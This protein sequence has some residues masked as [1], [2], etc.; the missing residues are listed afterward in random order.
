[1]PQHIEYDEDRIRQFIMEKQAN[2]IELAWD[3]RDVFNTNEILV[4]PLRQLVSFAV[5][6]LDDLRKGPF[7]GHQIVTAA[8]KKEVKG[9]KNK[10]LIKYGNL[11]KLANNAP[12]LSAEECSDVIR[13]Y[14]EVVEMGGE[15]Y[16]AQ[17]KAR[18]YTPAPDTLKPYADLD[19]EKGSFRRGGDPVWKAGRQ[20]TRRPP[21][22]PAKAPYDATY[23][24]T[25]KLE[26]GIST[27]T[28]LEKSTVLKI[29]RVFGLM[30]AAD[31]SGT[32]TDS[33]FFV[34]RYANMFRR[35]FNQYPLL[36]G[37]LDD[38]I[39]QLLALATLVAGGHHSVLESGLSLTLN[40]HITSIDYRIGLYTSLIPLRSAHPARGD[41]LSKLSL[42]EKNVRNR[43]MLVYYR[44]PNRIGGCYLFAKDGSER[45]RFEQLARGDTPL[46]HSFLRFGSW[47]TQDQVLSL[48]QRQR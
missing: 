8:W 47:P 3:L 10:A 12:Y 28:V 48:F 9:P 17:Q 25:Y 35:Y 27:A 4:G 1:M 24:F 14:G 41:V 22:T 29:D 18:R 43:L 26:G 33:I 32:T 16:K 37:A 38:P 11:T 39:Y 40:R 36:A 15:K 46:L 23:D 45:H 13:Y 6:E 34:N 20:R 5:D 44:E 7:E 30:V 21:T 42:A 31:I 19:T 2:E